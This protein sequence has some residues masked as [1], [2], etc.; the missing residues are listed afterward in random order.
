[1]LSD[2]ATPK[3]IQLLST[4]LKRANLMKFFCFQVTNPNVQAR[5]LS[6]NYNIINYDSYY[7]INCAIHFPVLAIERAS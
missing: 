3:H 7:I 4:I 1:M 2:E 5:K 6:C